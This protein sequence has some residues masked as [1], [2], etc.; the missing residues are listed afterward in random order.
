VAEVAFGD[1]AVEDGAGL[2]G[3]E[4]DEVAVVGVGGFGGE[5]GHAE[6]AGAG[7]GVEDGEEGA[8]GEFLFRHFFASVEMR[9]GGDGWRVKKDF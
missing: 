8:G 9:L 6:Q 4:V 3:A 5:A 7:V 1:G 2:E